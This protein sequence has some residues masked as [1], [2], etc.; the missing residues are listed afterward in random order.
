MTAP[1]ETVTRLSRQCAM[2]LEQRAGTATVSFRGDLDLACERAFDA[3]LAKVIQGAP[4]ALHVD[5]REVT[6]VDSTGLR[7]LLELNNRAAREDT[8]VSLLVSDGPVKRIL[9]ETGLDAVLPVA[10]G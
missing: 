4:A 2:R 9:S 6:F 7:L 5:L 8:D 10:S 3:E 1:V